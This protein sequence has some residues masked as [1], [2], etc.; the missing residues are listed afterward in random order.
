M[1]LLMILSALSL[2]WLCRT[3]GYRWLESNREQWTWAQRWQGNLLVFLWSPLLLFM[4]AIAVLYMGPQGHMVWVRE[5]GWSYAVA[6]GF[7]GVAACLNLKLLMEGWSSLQRIY[8]CSQTR[9]QGHSAYQIDHALP[10]AAQVGFWQSE[11]VITKGLVQVLSADQ[12]A[13]VLVHEQ[14]H[15][16]YR[17]TFW[18]FWWGWLRRLTAWLPHSTELWQELLLLRELRADQWA[19]QQVDPLVLAESLLLMVNPYP[20]EF[21]ENICAAM[22]TATGHRL[23]ERIDALIDPRETTPPS[24]SWT[25]SGLLVTAAPL[26]TIPFHY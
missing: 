1:H 24:Y 19:A 13:A 7:V 9:I 26:L 16:Q 14:A 8:A 12:L 18:F 5:N 11:L 4:T 21:A 20:A 10:Y 25:W 23:S 17:D 15:Q 2:A 22:Q 3:Y 6:A